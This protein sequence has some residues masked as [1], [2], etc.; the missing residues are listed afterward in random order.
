MTKR[1]IAITALPP[2]AAVKLVSL[3]ERLRAHRSLNQW[4]IKEMATRLLCSPGTYRALEA[5]KPTTSTGMLMSALFHI[6]T[7]A[8]VTE[9]SVRK[10]LA[11]NVCRCTGYQNIIDA[12]VDA[13]HRLK[14]ETV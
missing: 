3:G 11:G 2:G 7:E 13:A 12:V 4:T 1:S 5:G 10:A 6:Q 14:G 9:K 8:Q